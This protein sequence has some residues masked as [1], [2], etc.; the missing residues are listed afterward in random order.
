MKILL[1]KLLALNLAMLMLAGALLNAGIASAVS[2]AAAVGIT[3]YGNGGTTVDGEETYFPSESPECY[4]PFPAE[5][6]YANH[7]LPRHILS[8]VLSRL[9]IELFLF[10]RA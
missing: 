7:H 1:K 6:L 4:S 10:I 5:G 8:M 9:F 2:T 3:Y